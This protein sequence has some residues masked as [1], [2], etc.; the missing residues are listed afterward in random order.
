MSVNTKTYRRRRLE[1]D[2]PD[3]AFI[4]EDGVGWLRVEPAI[5]SGLPRVSKQLLKLEHNS[6]VI[7]PASGYPR[8]LR[9]FLDIEPGTRLTPVELNDLYED[10]IILG[11]SVLRLVDHMVNEL[12]VH[13]N[14]TI[15]HSNVEKSL[16]SGECFAKKKVS[17]SAVKTPLWFK[18]ET[19]SIRYGNTPYLSNLKPDCFYPLTRT[20][21]LDI[22][23]DTQLTCASTNELFESR[24][25]LESLQQ[26]MTLTL[27]AVYEHFSDIYIKDFVRLEQSVRHKKEL[28]E[29][30]LANAASVLLPDQTKGESLEH[31]FCAFSTVCKELGYPSEPLS[32]PPKKVNKHLSDLLTHNNL[33]SRKVELTSDWFKQDCGPL[34]AF[35]ESS[36]GESIP[37][38]LIRRRGKYTL[39]QKGHPPENVTQKLANEINVAG[40]QLYPDLPQDVPFTPKTIFSFCFKGN[41]KAGLTIACLG[42]LAG[43]CGFGIP[44]AMAKIVDQV[45]PSGELEG[46]AQIITALMM[47]TLGSALFE[48]I[49]GLALLR[50][51]TTWQ[52]GLQSAIF[53]HLLRLPTDFF[54]KFSAGDLSSRLSTVDSIRTQLSGAAITTLISCIFGLSNLA[55][56][57]IYSWQLA[58]ALTALLF[59]TFSFVWLIARSQMKAMLKMQNVI[60]KQ[61]GLELQMVTGITK[62]RT[63]GAEVN[64]F[65][66]WMGYF[67]EVRKLSLGIGMGTA[68]VTVF[69]SL[70]PLISGITAFSL[71]SFSG[72]IENLS[73]GSFL[74]FNVAMGQLTAAVAA[75]CLSALTLVYIRTSYLRVKPILDVKTEAVG[76][77]KDPGNLAGGLQ[78]NQV[79]YAY[80]KTS[81]LVLKDVSIQVK[82][83]E[84]VAVV[85]DSGCGKSTLMKMMM[86]FYQPLSGSVLYDD[87]N[88]SRLN[89]EK[90]RQQLGVVMQNGDLVQGDIFFNIA[91]SDEGATEE[92]VWKAAKLAN[93]EEDIRDMPMQLKTFVPHGGVTFSGGQRQRI[94]LARAFYRNSKILFLDEATSNLDNASQF[95]VMENLKHMQATRFVIAHRLSTIETADRIYVMENGEIVE[96]GTFEELIEAKG[97]FAKMVDRQRL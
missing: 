19:N 55:L 12:S 85:G 9:V 76:R 86:G 78:I 64:I 61:A 73:L 23:A 75:I 32:S 59:F 88:L 21:W 90:V 77:L 51:Q 37:V 56:M 47:I 52:V 50:A 33:F 72:L 8:Q 54:R 16:I 41:V 1:L 30:A 95:E 3:I 17:L 6:L 20:L 5:D 22:E 49:K 35:K 69:S 25:I 57:L 45:I 74:C 97:Q 68:V 14:P 93:I 7:G 38:A 71:V 31:L 18:P 4:L 70:L 48:L 15:P 92:K 62:L 28:M 36:P 84:F 43:I 13:V 46:L 94:M 63:T 96:S 81:N 42:L 91:G 40:V 89:I 60:G 11:S 65:S 39:H 24:H 58:L 44:M 82:A 2:S 67:T 29:Q 27:F 53:A 79:S 83:G 66:R 34:L 87:K 80:P 10:D 26:F